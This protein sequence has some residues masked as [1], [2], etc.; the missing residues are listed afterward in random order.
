M[1]PE[2]PLRPLLA[3]LML[4]LTG[5]SAE[6]HAT[7]G[8]ESLD[9]HEL[10]AAEAHFR[11]ALDREPALPEA[12]AGL[13]WTYQIAGQ[14]EAAEGAFKKCLEVLPDEVS[15]LRGMASVTLASGN[16]A[17]AQELLAKA[18][19]L[20]PEDPGVQ[21]SQAILEMTLGNL[22]QAAARYKG[23]VERYPS[24]AEYQLGYAEVLLRQK[25]PEE[26]LAQVDR[27]L[28]LPETPPRFVSM[29]HM[30]RAR[31]LVATT[32]G[33]INPKDCAGTAPPVLAWL[34]AADEALLSAK[35][36]GVG[37]DISQ[38]QR[39]VA[40]RRGAVEDRCPGA[41]SAQRAESL[42][43][44]APATPALISPPPVQRAKPGED[45]AD[46]AAP[47]A[48]AGDAADDGVTSP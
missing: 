29:L 31:T 46:P 41:A 20:A 17:T 15:C 8:R 27:A 12:L 22:D 37:T 45:A 30:L 36:A 48:P 38:V 13:G 34:E 24:M 9:A 10:S 42:P 33:R 25:K 7:K 28:A 1:T 14:R 40:R 11:K 18:L 47:A 32:S 4:G 43:T 23:L 21:G 26:A 44:L 39:L 5:C 19:Q 3:L 35:A 2:T 16:P 6:Y